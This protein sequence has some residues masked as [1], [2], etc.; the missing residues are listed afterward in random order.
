MCNHE[1]PFLKEVVL[2][3]E[4]HKKAHEQSQAQI[5]KVFTFFLTLKNYF[6]C[7]S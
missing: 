3:E 1:F 7:L 2:L 5:A 4:K 6:Q